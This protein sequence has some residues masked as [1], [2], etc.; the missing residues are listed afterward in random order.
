MSAPTVAVVG[1]VATGRSYDP[2]LRDVAVAARAAEEIGRELAQHG[3]RLVVFSSDEGF[4]ESA[5]VRGY[6]QS[7]RARPGAIEVRGPYRADPTDFPEAQSHPELFDTRPEPTPDWEVSFY[8]ALLQVDAILL[9]GGGRSTFIAGLIALSRRIAAA[10]VGTFGG[11]A[12]KAW[13]RMHGEPDAASEEDLSAMVSRWRPGSAEAVV[14]SLLRQHERRLSEQ[15]QLQRQTTVETRRRAWS[16]LSALVFLAAG[17]ATLPAATAWRP[18]TWAAVTLLVFG[19]LCAAVS[20][21]LIRNVFDEVGEWLRAAVFGAAAGGLSAVLFLAA[22]LTTNPNLLQ[23]DSAARLGY[24]IVPVGFAAGLAFDA[25][26]TKLRG[27]DV[28]KTHPVDAATP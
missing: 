15:E 1:S 12:E 28:V 24:F 7:G 18:G 11:S 4:V 8:R 13:Q 10:P 27:T 23:G 3:C 9:I 25:V 26:L 19:P 17:L 21:A 5:V 6:A 14:G 20:G 2:P 16:L 22:Q